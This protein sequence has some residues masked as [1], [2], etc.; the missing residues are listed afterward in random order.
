ME[1]LRANRVGT[2]AACAL[3]VLGYLAVRWISAS[4]SAPPPPRKVMQFTVVNLQQQPPR[5]PVPP[6][7]QP[8]VQPK[9]VEQVRTRVELKPTDF[10]PPDLSRPSP[11]PSGGGRLALAA[12]GE[13]P[14]D[15]FNLAGNPGGRG[16]L[17]GGGLGDGDGLGGEGSGAG[18]KFGWYYAK[19]A[20]EIEEAFRRLKQLRS[21]QVRAELRVWTDPAGRISRVQ[22]VRSTG[23]P[24]VDEAIQSIVGLRLE[25]PP[26]R[27]IPMPMIARL[28]ARRPQ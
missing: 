7:P 26:P 5:Q 4:R 16:L 28:T 27:D 17:S 2:V 1:L 20:T 22:L 6:P 13:G 8:A 14:G 19:L 24:K 9:I 3:I 11:G 10:S 25:E 15:S 23:D 12:E 21:A 18:S